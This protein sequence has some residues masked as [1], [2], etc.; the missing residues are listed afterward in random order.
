MDTLYT[1]VTPFLS[2][3]YM[4]NK[5]TAMAFSN[6]LI[7]FQTLTFTDIKGDSFQG[8][9]ALT[10]KHIKQGQIVHKTAQNQT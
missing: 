5:E 7:Y 3:K 10:G 6:Q 1:N 8:S 4:T 9:V 2:K